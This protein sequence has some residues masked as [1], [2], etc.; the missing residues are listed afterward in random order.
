LKNES[1][2]ANFNEDKT[3]VFIGSGPLPLTLIMFN[4]VFKCRCI[5]IEVQKEVAELSKKVLKKVRIK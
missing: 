4:K 3:V 1:Q 2:L 5:G